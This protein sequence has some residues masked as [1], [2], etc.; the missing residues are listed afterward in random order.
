MSVKEYNAYIDNVYQTLVDHKYKVDRTDLKTI[1]QCGVLN[2]LLLEHGSKSA[3][4]NLSGFKEEYPNRYIKRKLRDFIL[5]KKRAPKVEQEIKATVVQPQSEDSD[6]VDD[7]DY[8]E[9]FDDDDEED[10]SAQDV[11]SSLN[12]NSLD[13]LTQNLLNN[14]KSSSS[15][16]DDLDTLEDDFD[17]GDALASFSNLSNLIRTNESSFYVEEDDDSAD[18][19]VPFDRYSDDMLGISSKDYIRPIESSENIGQARTALNEIKSGKPKEELFMEG[20][21]ALTQVGVKQLNRI[22]E[23]I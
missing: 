9:D 23:R 13:D 4:H 5:D 2:I 8:D 15:V 3:I 16:S 7:D 6:F 18:E 10:D 12:F 22:L 17:I 20:L 21:I 14:A 1:E 19:Y 11:A